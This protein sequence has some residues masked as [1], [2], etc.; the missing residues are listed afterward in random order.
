[1]LTAIVSGPDDQ[2]DLEDFTTSNTSTLDLG[3]E[4]RTEDGNIGADYEIALRNRATAVTFV[5][6]LRVD[7]TITYGIAT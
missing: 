7:F 6:G 2:W 5:P 4:G 3:R 1:M